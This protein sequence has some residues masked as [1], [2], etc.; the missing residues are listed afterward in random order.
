[1]FDALFPSTTAGF[2]EDR[3]GRGLERLRA[4]PGLPAREGALAGRFSQG[5][6]PTQEPS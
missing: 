1:V 2:E 4:P 3:T 5:T 6:A